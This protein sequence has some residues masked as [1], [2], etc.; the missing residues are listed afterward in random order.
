[1]STT[2][3]CTFDIDE[4]GNQVQKIIKTTVGRVLFNE[5]V[6]AKAGYIN[7]VLTKKSLRGIIGGI[8]KVYIYL[9]YQP[10]LIRTIFYKGYLN[11]YTHPNYGI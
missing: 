7:E 9:I 1:M 6:P 4:N 5:V 8:L 2:K 11:I 3:E 10:D